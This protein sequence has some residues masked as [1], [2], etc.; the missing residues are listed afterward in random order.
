MSFA[1]S[2]NERDE[3]DSGC[4]GPVVSE[5]MWVTLGKVGQ[6][7]LTSLCSVSFSVKWGIVMSY[8]IGLL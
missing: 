8:I 2:Y 3:P 5:S 6:S 7:Y 1:I 4:V